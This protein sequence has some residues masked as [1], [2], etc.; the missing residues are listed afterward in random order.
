MYPVS[1]AFLEAIESNTRKYYWT[2]TITTVNGVSYPF[3]NKDIVKGSGYITRQCCGST[4]IELGTVYAAEL[5]ISLFSDIDR[6]TLEGAEVKLYFHL[7]LADGTV[8]SIPMGVFEVSEANRNIKTLELKAYDYMLRFDK[9]LSLNATSGTAFHYLAAACSACKVE[10][11]Q[12]QAEIEKLPNGKETLGV[13]AENDMET[14]RDLLFYVG[15]VLG[16]VCLI[17]R[18]GKLQLVPY[19]NTAVMTIPQK[20][21]YTSSYSDFVTRYTAVSST[22]QLRKVAEY[23]ALETDDALTMNLGVNP[24]LQFGLAATRERILTAILNA[25]AKVEYIPFD[26]C[27]IGNPALDPMDILQFTGGH[28]D[29]TKISC[30]TSITYNINGKNSLKCVGKNP[31]LSSAKSKNEKNIAG[32]LNQVEN[33][34][35]VIYSFMNVSPF[36]I[37]SSATEV[38]SITFT[39]K[40]STSAMF[41][42]EFLID[43]VADDTERFVEG[44]AT[45]TVQEAESLVKKEQA[46]T[47]TFI[48]KIQPVLTVTYKINDETVH[49]FI[50]QMTC[51]HGKHILT[52]FYPMSAIIENSENTFD[53]Y[54]SVDGGTVNIG[55][56]QIRATISGQG[57]VAGVGDWNGRISINEIINRIAISDVPFGYTAISD[58]TV[59]THPWLDYHAVTQAIARIAITDVQFGYDLLNERITATEV[60]KTFT[61][62]A[63]YPPHY[64]MT[65]VGLNDDGAFVMACDYAIVSAEEE[66]D[67][68]R[69]QHLMVNTTQYERVKSLEVELC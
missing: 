20:G 43:V 47:F 23:Y 37:G 14:Y 33:N 40:E 67:H 2:G 48:E 9:S 51:V 56:S 27:T 58:S 13:Y 54:L 4:E 49:T 46:V 22:N 69:M 29:N 31:K 6:Y 12:T 45:Y 1:N 21:R 68:G 28:A 55:E 30:I 19:S 8:E 25:I 42:G 26:S 16:C 3:E 53:V 60:I 15:Q 7:Y 39:A 17:N 41:L 66:I 11:A 61:I 59:A 35:T 65:F 57:L 24:L 38:L 34:K 36:S 50:P 5:G 18:E 10:L 62:D 44:T 64:N 32:L 63:E 52:L